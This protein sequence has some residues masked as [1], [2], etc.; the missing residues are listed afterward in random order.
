[1]FFKILFCY[2]LLLSAFFTIS[3]VECS[4][5]EVE[6][7]KSL[8]RNYSSLVRPVKN[9]SKP[10]PVFIKVFLQQIINVDEQNQVVEINAWL[11]Y[12]WNDYRLR[13]RPLS[14]D[15]ITSVRFPG[16]ESP[17]WQ[18]D[19]LLYNSADDR[20]DSS[21]KSNLVVYSSGLVNWIPPG[22][23]KISC[24]MDI[25]MFPFDEQICFMKFGSWTYHGFSIDLQVDTEKEDT[26]AVDLSTY[27][28]NGEWR[29]INAPAHREVKFYKCCL[30]PYPT[31]KFYMYIRRRALYYAFNVVIP[32][33][34][35]SLMT[36]LAFCLPADDMSE[37]IGFQTTILL[38]VCFF[39][40]ILSEMVPTTSESIPLLGMFFSALTLIVSI[41]TIFTI[42]VL[43]IRYRQYANHTMSPLFRQVF[44]EWIPWLVLL[45][46]P[47]HKYIKGRCVN[48]SSSEFHDCVQCAYKTGDA[49]SKCLEEQG[50]EDPILS[51]LASEKLGLERKV[52]EGIFMPKRF[53]NGKRFRWTQYERC[54]KKC[55]QL[56][57]EEKSDDESTEMSLYILNIY[58]SIVS[59][60]R[61]VR[62]YVDRKSLKKMNKEEWMMA[63]MALDRFC[64]ILFAIFMTVVIGTVFFASPKI[65]M[66]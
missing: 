31:I 38:S 63:A 56:V 13:W 50:L 47:K 45:K 15:N 39:L 23:F 57:K 36:L 34:L 32:S 12:T 24:K 65:D 64:L 29:L 37:K 18:P 11:K 66:I 8:L 46:R 14:Y 17:I 55:I 41:T 21:F 33:L 49:V 42:A 2:V 7:Y 58:S 19:I 4:K 5:A 30:E 25:T 40:T 53:S 10:L 35:I 43:N 3:E 1:M 22:I 44:L 26:P 20:F 9:P 62:E 52:G 61:R 60:I 6:L 27:I 59:K 16:G 51:T 54:L 48:V 28:S